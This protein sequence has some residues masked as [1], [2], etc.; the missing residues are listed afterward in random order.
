VSAPSD[1]ALQFRQTP[2]RLRVLILSA[3][4]GA[5]AVPFLAP[6]LPGAQSPASA[7]GVPQWMTVLVLVVLSVLNVE[8][9]RA[10]VGGLERTQQ[11]HKALSAWA[12]ACALLL[13]APWL[14]VVVP[15][16]YAHARWRGLRVP[17]W[18]WV[19]SACYLVL[20]GVASGLVRAAVYGG[21]ADWMSGDGGRGVV[22]MAAAAAVFLA[23][24]T[25]LFTGS[26]LLNTAEDEVWLRRTLRS[27]SFY[28]TEAA[29]LL[30]GGLL[31]AVWTGGP[32]FILLFVPVYAL[33]QRAALVDPLRVRAAAAAQLDVKNRELERAHQF[34]VDLLGILGHEMGNPVTSVLGYA[35]VAAESLSRADTDTTHH[36][37]AA[38]RRNAEQLQQ[39]LSEVLTFVTSD[40]G[41]LVAHPEPCLVGPHLRDAAARRPGGGPAVDCPED[42]MTLVQP[43]HLDQILANLLSNADKYAGGATCLSA[44][45]AGD[46]VVEILVADDGPGVPPKFRERLFERFSR[47]TDTTDR[48]AGTGLGLFITRELARANHGEVRLGDDEAAGPGAT[49]VLRLPRFRGAEVTGN[50]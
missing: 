21:Q 45:A 41:V 48:V 34:K 4:V 22:A 13:P 30:I 23:V 44:R 1:S 2:L 9:S 50:L 40:A 35:E 12:F 37:L 42:L 46:G 10:L 5:V 19:G 26:A 16:T 43:G 38:V 8:I 36:A 20:A 15:A 24:E 39:V 11:P 29:V 6:H 49:F 14:L 18:K 3:A 47:D 33:V 27:S 32:W 28:G 25:V 17:L 7:F 31:A